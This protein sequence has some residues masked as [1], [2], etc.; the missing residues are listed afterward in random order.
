MVLDH[1]ILD[2][3]H[4]TATAFDH[5]PPPDPH[6]IAFDTHNM[7]EPMTAASFFFSTRVHRSGRT[8]QEVA[9]FFPTEPTSFASSEPTS[10]ASFF[11]KRPTSFD[12]ADEEPGDDPRTAGP[13]ESDPKL[14]NG[15]PT[16]PDGLPLSLSNPV[17][18]A[19]SQIHK[20]CGNLDYSATQK[21]IKM[22][23]D[24]VAYARIK[25]KSWTKGAGDEVAKAI[26][27]AEGKNEDAPPPPMPIPGRQAKGGAEPMG[28]SGTW[29]DEEVPSAAAGSSVPK[30]P[31]EPQAAAQANANSM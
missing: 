2:H 7:A 15:N 4:T 1:M 31:K 6:T 16:G 27:L 20:K 14:S 24:A 22:S 21:L 28:G 5:A 11:P 17:K 19:V 30:V 13:D 12:G 25:M 10:F 9:S 23:E 18:Y 29:L 8:F 26:A 3:V